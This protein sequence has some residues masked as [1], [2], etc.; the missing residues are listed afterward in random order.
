MYFE[1]ALL[2]AFLSRDFGVG[3]DVSG[4]FDAF[5]DA[6]NDD[7]DGGGHGSSDMG[8]GHADIGEGYFGK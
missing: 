6:Y 4:M 1:Q 5:F 3:H 7:E 8:R 2:R